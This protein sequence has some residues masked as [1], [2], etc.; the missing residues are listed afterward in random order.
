MKNKWIL[1]YCI[2]LMLGG[3]FGYIKSGSMMSIITSGCSTLAILCCLGADSAGYKWGI[4]G[5]YVCIGALAVFFG[6]RFYS[7]GNAMPGGLMCLISLMLLYN[8]QISSGKEEKISL[9]DN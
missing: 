5:A 4:K 9:A 2:M 1:S 7:T 8:A 3:S 6:Y